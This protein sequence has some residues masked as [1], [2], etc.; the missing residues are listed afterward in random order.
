MMEEH[1]AKYAALADEL[2][3]KELEQLVAP[4]AQRNAWSQYRRHER[5]R[6]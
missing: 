2:G 6:P 3:R 5:G 4:L 1:R